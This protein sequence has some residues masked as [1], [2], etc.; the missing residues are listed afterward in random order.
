MRCLNKII[1][2]R[3]MVYRPKKHNRKDAQRNN[4]PSNVRNLLIKQIPIISVFE[5]DWDV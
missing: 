2:K 3:K 4:D 5:D 1:E